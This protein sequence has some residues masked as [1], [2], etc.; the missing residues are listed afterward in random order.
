[1]PVYNVSVKA[2]RD[3]TEMPEEGIRSFFD[4]VLWYLVCMRGLELGSS[5]QAANALND[6]DILI[7]PLIISI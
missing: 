6:Y 4:S 7:D 3:I 5:E 1:M 2:H